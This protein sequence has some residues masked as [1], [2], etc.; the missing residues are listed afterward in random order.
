MSKKRFVAA[1]ATAA[2]GAFTAL[3]ARDKFKKYVSAPD[4]KRNLMDLGDRAVQKVVGK[5]ADSVPDKGLPFLNRY[6]NTGFMEGSGW[7]L[8][9]PARNAFWS[10]GYAKESVMPKEYDGDLYLGGYLAFP[11]NKVTGVI[12]EQMVRAVAVDDNSGRGVHVFAVIDCIGIS[13]TDIRAIRKEL[14]GLIAEKNIL[15]VNISATHCHSGVDTMGL[16]G[17]LIR[18]VRKN[19][20]AVGKGHPEQAVSGRN[21]DFMN[22]LIK[23]AAFTIRAAVENMKPGNLSYARKDIAD[24]VHDKRPP[25]VTDHTLTALR[26]TP[27]DGGRPL[28]AVFMAAHPTCYGPHQTEAICDFPKFMCTK[29]EECGSDAMFVQ[30]AQC[31]VATDRGRHVPEGLTNEE[32]IKAYGEAIAEF[33][34]GIDAAEYKAIPPFINVIAGELFLPAENKI[35]ELAA[36]LKLVNNAIVRVTMNNDRFVGTDEREL[37]FPTE[38]GFT[39]LGPDLRLAMVPG[40]LMPEIAVGGAYEDWES[41]NGKPWPYPPLKDIL[42]GDLA[43]IGLCNDFIGYIIPDNDFGSMFAPL[44]YE[45]SV[46]AGGRTASN[47]VSGFIRLKE[48][49]DKLRGNAPIP[50]TED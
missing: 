6:D 38:I 44:H 42:G 8:D 49:A 27:D 48:K 23:T 5:L 47:I 15:S 30:G 40:E 24:F 19:K 50:M 20:K 36:K 16:W 29:L 34:N 3:A 32:S 7:F 35:L 33:V 43:V 12:D 11:P 17:D 14:S 37:Y 4:N 22:Y 9:A 31:A 25:Y 13:G 39:E 46:S 18:A 45:E 26:F 10:V 28:T 2:A 41:Y 1:A 21:P